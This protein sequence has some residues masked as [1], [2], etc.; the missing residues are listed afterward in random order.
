ML[1][2]LQ[3]QQLKPGL[4]LLFVFGAEQR[5]WQGDGH[6]ER[7]RLQERDDLPARLAAFGGELLRH[8]FD[9]LSVEPAFRQRRRG[10]PPDGI[11]PIAQ[12]GHHQRA[13]L[14]IAFRIQ[15]C[16]GEALTQIGIHEISHLR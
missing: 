4:H 14:R 16:P 12:H 13:V 11:A 7:L 15:K 1:C 3:L 5:A 9:V 6:F 8:G 2:L 10:A